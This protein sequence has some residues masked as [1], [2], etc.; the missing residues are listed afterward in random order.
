M[1]QRRIDLHGFE[2]GNAAFAV[3]LGTEGAHIVQAVAELDKDN[4]YVFC[5]SKQ[6]LTQVFD[7]SLFL[8]FDLQLNDFG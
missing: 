8:V 5:H 4:A 3:L 6:H 7:M 2:C 1:R